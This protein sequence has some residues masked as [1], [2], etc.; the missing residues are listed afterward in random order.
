MNTNNADTK[1]KPPLPTSVDRQALQTGDLMLY[2]RKNLARQSELQQQRQQNEAADAQIKDVIEPTTP[3]TPD[4]ASSLSDNMADDDDEVCAICLKGDFTQDNL[5]V[6]CEGKCKLGFHQKCYGISEI[7]P[8]DEPWYCDWCA[9]GNK[10]TYAKNLYCCHYKNDKSARTLVIEGKPTEQHFVHV[11][12]AAWI[13]DVDTSTLPFTTK[14]P[15]LKAELTKCYFCEARFG[16]Q[17]RCSHVH[18]GVQCETT[19]HPM[20]ALRYKFLDPPPIYNAKYSRHLCPLH[21][22]STSTSTSTSAA[23]AAASAARAASSAA[24][25]SSTA[26]LT[27][28]RRRITDAH[29]SRAAKRPYRRQT[30]PAQGPRSRNQKISLAEYEDDMPLI[31]TTRSPATT[32][33]TPKQE[34]TASSVPSTAKSGKRRY[35]R[36][37][38][39]NDDTRSSPAP[40]Q[41]LR[42]AGRLPNSLHD[43]MSE[44]SSEDAAAFNAPY[45][46]SKGRRRYQMSADGH[47]DIA[48]SVDGDVEAGSNSGA[49]ENA[50]RSIKIEQSNPRTSP[51]LDTG[52]RAASRAPSHPPLSHPNGLQS[53]KDRRKIT[54]TFNGQA[55][56]PATNQPAEASDSMAAAASLQKQEHKKE[57]EPDSTV[58]NDAPRV[59]MVSGMPYHQMPPHRLPTTN[60]APSQQ[61]QL[62]KRPAIRVRP[63]AQPGVVDGTVP[64]PSTIYQPISPGVKGFNAESLTAKLSEEHALMIK[65]SHDMLARQ[66]EMLEKIHELVSELTSQ[67]TKQAQ[68]AMSTISSLTAL[69]S[70]TNGAPSAAPPVPS[71]LQNGNVFAPS[72]Q[73]Q[74][75]PNAHESSSGNSSTASSSSTIGASAPA[76]SLN[77]PRPALSLNKLY[78]K[79]TEEKPSTSLASALT[80]RQTASPS[81]QLPKPPKPLVAATLASDIAMQHVVAEQPSAAY[82]S[83][84][85]PHASQAQSAQ[86]ELDELKAN[87]LSLI[88]LV[89]MPSVLAGVFSAKAGPSTD[90]SSA[91][92]SG[93]KRVSSIKTLVADLKQLGALSRDNVADYVKT[94]IRNLEDSEPS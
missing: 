33:I 62:P 82:P 19:F 22:P 64:R 69:I 84:N 29:H 8:G 53:M 41:G 75:E 2:Y 1:H 72:K 15:K 38:Y 83:P 77:L 56:T 13:P 5:I 61:S 51:H 76:K 10:Q 92:S 63:F 24:A 68:N 87:V 42:R 73:P 20:C 39:E 80:P 43:D 35:R 30:L 46:R 50:R 9:G 67:P 14:V 90:S 18:H 26:G 11:Q 81:Q 79:G 16:Y 47:N 3:D 60:K 17:I 36:R 21:S 88:K 66:G 93:G 59:Q 70:N 52:S 54:L 6:F 48:D 55:G 12:C 65:G 37:G 85:Q 34:M 57:N 58:Q 28:K 31:L 91:G 32:P 78:N 44:T 7:P 86:A 27:A 49:G 45:R 89:N 25:T 23:A 4:T 94:I 74:K 40:S 71:L